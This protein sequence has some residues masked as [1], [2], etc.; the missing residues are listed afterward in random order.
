M[1]SPYDMDNTMVKRGIG[2]IVLAIIAALLLGYL[3]KDKSRE[4]QEIVAMDLPGAPKITIPSLS[5]TTNKVT[6]SAVSLL[7]AKGNED[8]L[9]NT[10]SNAFAPIAESTTANTNTTTTNP[11][12]SFRPPQE[13]EEQQI[14]TSTSSSS[15]NTVAKTENNNTS[16]NSTVVNNPPKTSI[17]KQT[18]KAVAK[19]EVKQKFKPVI[20]DNPKKAIKKIAKKAKPVV[21]S[22]SGGKYSIQLLA[23]SSRSRAGK[24]AKTM[25]S[26]GYVSFITQTTNNN[27]IL[28]RVRVGGHKDRNEALAVQQ[29]MKRRYQKN[30][31]V[32]N[33]LVVS[34]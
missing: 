1:E 34:Q 6:N 12:F 21:A 27:K 26:E 17:K 32:Q 23:T 3:L 11:G 4:R 7:V 5:D 25:N 31:F 20:E 14:N 10:N 2:A 13:N 29:S 16:V 33:S 15:S 22:S 18:K 24:L 8:K 9:R 19:K 28:Y 30:F